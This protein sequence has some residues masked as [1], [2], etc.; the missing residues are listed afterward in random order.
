[1]RTDSGK[2]VLAS[3]IDVTERRLAEDALRTSQRE[4][5]E[6]SGSLIGA[7]EGERR[8]IARELHDDFSQT[9]ALL[10][11][12]MELVRQKLPESNRELRPRIE[13][14]ADRVRRLSSAMHELSHELHPLK[15]EQLGLA[16]AIRS[17]CK[18]V[19]QA[20]QLKV[21]FL[22]DNLLAAIPPDT[23]LCLYRVVQEALRNVV[24]H[25]GAQRA[26][27]H[28]QQSDDAISLRIVDAGSGFD[29]AS[30]EGEHGLGFISMRERLRLVG[31]KIDIDSQPSRGTRIVV[32]APLQATKATAEVELRG[33]SVEV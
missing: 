31:G 25:S 27:V 32:S 17:L 11:V 28:L 29:A 33:Q 2:F 14:L 26:E 30:L 12:E 15:L 9:L 21:D 13:Q 6:L 4:L 16:P 10:N 20:H 22:A 7:Q 8:R 23:A 24:R 19:S 1:M 18:E 3:V 5:Q